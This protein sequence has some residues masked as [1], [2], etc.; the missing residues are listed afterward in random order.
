MD[1]ARLL[2]GANLQFVL[3]RVRARTRSLHLVA[4]ASC[5]GFLPVPGTDN[6]SLTDDACLAR[7]VRDGASPTSPVGRREPASAAARGSGAQRLRQ[8]SL[9]CRSNVRRR[10]GIGLRGTGFRVLSIDYDEYCAR[11]WRRS[12]WA[13]YG[14][15]AQFQPTG[16]G[17][18]S[19][20]DG[21][22]TA[23][24][25]RTAHGN[26]FRFLAVRSLHPVRPERCG[27]RGRVRRPVLLWRVLG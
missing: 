25:G 14:F 12:G 26:R 27:S 2:G 10:C 21:G 11:G 7:V 4:K 22:S 24:F 18:W 16:G 20:H 8:L 13:G 5:W 3:G 19:S 15:F 1:V 6:T 9:S 23:S 17:R